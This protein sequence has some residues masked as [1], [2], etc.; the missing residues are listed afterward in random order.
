MCP[1]CAGQ[2]EHCK[3]CLGGEK[4]KGERRMMINSIFLEVWF[5][6]H[7]FRCSILAISE[8]DRST[9]ALEG[10]VPCPPKP[11]LSLPG[12]K[13]QKPTHSSSAAASPRQPGKIRAFVGKGEIPNFGVAKNYYYYYFKLPFFYCLIAALAHLCSKLSQQQNQSIVSVSLMVG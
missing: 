2:Q 12:G 6:F 4:Y 10:A 5:L 1:S 3:P 7:H 11:L 13:P 9:E 8:P